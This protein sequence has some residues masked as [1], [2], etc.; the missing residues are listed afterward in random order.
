[1]TDAGVDTL[2][3]LEASKG[4]V[5]L[6]G[7]LNSCLDALGATKHREFVELLGSAAF[8]PVV[9]DLNGNITVSVS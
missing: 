8:I 9:N 7:T 3:F 1:M 5:A 4:V 2:A 6:F